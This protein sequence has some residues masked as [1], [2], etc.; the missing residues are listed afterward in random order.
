MKNFDEKT[1]QKAGGDNG[2]KMGG[3]SGC[4]DGMGGELSTINAVRGLIHKI[5][6]KEVMLDADLARIYGY[7]TKVFNRQV[8]RNI[9]KFE[10]EEFMF[11]ITKEEYMNLMCQNGT[12]SYDVI[13]DENLMLQNATSSCDGVDDTNLKSQNLTS[14]W[15]GVR[16]LPYAFTEQGV[17]MLMTVLRGELAVK[18]SRALVMAFKAM[19][20][21]ILENRM[22]VSEREDLK[23]MALV[24]ENSQQVGKIEK[25]ISVM[26]KR[27]TDIETKVENTVMRNEVAPIM[28][29]FNRFAESREYL[30]MENE[31]MEAKDVYQSIY[32]RAKKS[33]HLIDDYIDIRTLRLLRCVHDGVAVTIFL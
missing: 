8:K 1:N 24:A 27:L 2:G 21:Y 29:D 17:Y 15:G 33:V 12:S 31:L 26:D 3:A 14:S 7:E 11:Q 20:D 13:D 23:M 22:L 6:G 9:E 4:V 16:K 25:R 10:G 19:K 18:Q 30:F 28:L 32:L 5:R